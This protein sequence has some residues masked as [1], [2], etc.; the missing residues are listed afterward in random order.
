MLVKLGMNR[1]ILPG[2]VCESIIGMTGWT[3]TTGAKGELR[4][5]RPHVRW[6]EIAFSRASSLKDRRT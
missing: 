3:D 4:D 1:T 2:L 5:I 6:R